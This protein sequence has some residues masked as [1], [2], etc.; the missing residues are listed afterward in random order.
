MS[1]TLSSTGRV[2][3]LTA[4]FKTAPQLSVREIAHSLAQ[5]NRFTG[6]AQ[7]PIS[8]AEHSLLVC[9]ITESVLGLGLHAQL[10]ALMHDAHE[11]IT[12]DLATPMKRQ[13]GRAWTDMEHEW[14][15]AFIS[16]FGLGAA[17]AMHAPQL[18]QADLV[19]L[20][21]ERRDLMHPG[22]P[23]WPSLAGIEPLQGVNLRDR[24][25]F[26]WE[27]WREA[28]IDRHDELQHGL[29]HPHTHHMPHHMPHYINQAT[30]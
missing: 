3:D 30:A 27:D 16:A 26:T 15:R 2:L 23:P 19:A 17:W 5:I 8:V 28:F 22:G 21:T 13:M 20:A 14:A 18:H 1:W 11:C 6:H 12:N 24:D 9:D 29:T 25:A 4:P 10:A 7:R